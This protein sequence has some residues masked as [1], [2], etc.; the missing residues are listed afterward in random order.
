MSVF[1]F[2]V[3]SLCRR[4][5]Q[6][7]AIGG[8]VRRRNGEA[9]HYLPCRRQKM[10]TT[11]TAALG[12]RLNKSAAAVRISLIRIQLKTHTYSCSLL[13]FLSLS[14]SLFFFLS[15]LFFL[16]L[17]FFRRYWRALLYNT[18]YLPKQKLSSR[19]LWI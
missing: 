18:A 8:V 14:L 10:I 6:S 11:T 3:W 15:L 2:S 19:V 9:R 5:M 17:I 16:H 7:G 4:Y 12:G 13:L 1:R